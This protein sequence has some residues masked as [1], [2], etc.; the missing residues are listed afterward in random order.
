[1]DKIHFSEIRNL[2]QINA[3]DFV[4]VEGRLVQGEQL[5]RSQA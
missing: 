2:P 1:M 5:A 3:G 4:G